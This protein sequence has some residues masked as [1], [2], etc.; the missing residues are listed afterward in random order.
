M[1]KIIL[2]TFFSVL[3]TLLF[4]CTSKTVPVEKPFSGAQKQQS[5]IDTKSAPGGWET[6]WAATLELAK[7]ES[8]LV[9][10]GSP[11][12]EAYKAMAEGF[13]KNFGL[14]IE[15]VAGRSAEVVTKIKMEDRAGL[16]L[17]DVVLVGGSTAVIELAPFDMLAK[18]DPFLILPEV[19]DDK[20]WYKKSWQ[21]QILDPGHF[22]FSYVA[23]LDMLMMR[24]INMVGP[25]DIKGWESFLEPKW[26]GQL[27]I[28][29]PTTTG[30]GQ[31]NFAMVGK[32]KG[33]D[34]WRAI[35]RQSPTVLRDNRLQMEWLSQG[36]YP[37]LISPSTSSAQS[38]IDAGAPVAF[39]R[40]QEGNYTSSS[41]GVISVF[42]KA[43]HPNV[44]KIFLN[45]LLS[46]EGQTL[47]S[48]AD[49]VQSARI[50]VPTEGLN[51]LIIREP[52]V[53]YP[54]SDDWEF[55]GWRETAKVEDIAKEIFGPLLK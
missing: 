11:K 9:I 55:Y 17:G 49:G 22:S 47:W 37:M 53:M 19:M 21:N 42:K 31:S 41:G 51:P 32:M 29:D 24:N 36:K 7:K 39:I 33:W 48:K 4:A 38:F 30:K 1:R 14:N 16:H 5:Q 26:K 35:A 3:T 8:K 13:K 28:N 2:L 54:A 34:F 44:T 23:S 43:P 52:G 50:D 10:Y 6:E 12:P 45:Y 15:T 20:A 18:L 46:R 25:N 27:L 40:L